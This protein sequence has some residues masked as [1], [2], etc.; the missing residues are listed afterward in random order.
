VNL[1]C[2]STTGFSFADFQYTR[3]YSN[4]STPCLTFLNSNVVEIIFRGNINFEFALFTH[5]FHTC[6]LY[7]FFYYFYGPKTGYLERWPS[8]RRRTPGK[9]VIA[10]SGSW[11]R[12]PF[13]PHKQNYPAVSCRIIFL[14][15][16][17]PHRITKYSFLLK[18][19]PYTVIS[20]RRDTASC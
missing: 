19:P 20:P 11:V 10:K 12:I 3:R 13:S 17:P 14:L 5:I 8:G 1:N 18:N 16:S 7:R 6:I 2:I 15:G 4:S 9:C